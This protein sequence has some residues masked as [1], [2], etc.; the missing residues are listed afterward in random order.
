MLDKP[1]CFGVNVPGQARCEFTL[2]EHYEGWNGVVH[3]GIVCTILDEAMAHAYFPVARG[4]TAK[5]EFRFRQPARVGEPMVVTGRLVKLSR[6]LLR[7]EAEIIL[8]DGTVVAEGKAQAYVVG[9][10]LSV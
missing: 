3:V 2:S 6:K 10:G 1:A 7:A 4:L 9:P 5:A 8:R